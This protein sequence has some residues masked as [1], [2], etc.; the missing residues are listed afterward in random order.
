MFAHTGIS[1]SVPVYFVLLD[2]VPGLLGTSDRLVNG[3]CDFLEIFVGHFWSN[4]IH[5][6]SES[7]ITKELRDLKL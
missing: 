1:I 6:F 4:M 7:S 2:L 5:Y 3:T